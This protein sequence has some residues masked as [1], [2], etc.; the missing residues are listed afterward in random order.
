MLN[1]VLGRVLPWVCC[2]LSCILQ[3]SAVLQE[4][5]EQAIVGPNWD[6]QGGLWRVLRDI[7]LPISGPGSVMMCPTTLPEGS[8]NW[9]PQQRKMWSVCKAYIKA[10]VLR[11]D[12]LR[13]WRDRHLSGPLG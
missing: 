2:L 13:D 9:E 5:M 4:D 7:Q 3:L 6:G 1:S 12:A 11:S 8:Q 10:E